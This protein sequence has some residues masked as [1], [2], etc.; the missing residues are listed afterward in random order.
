MTESCSTQRSQGDRPTIY[1][2]RITVDD[3]LDYLAGG[4]ALSEFAAD[5]PD[6][7]DEDVRDSGF[8]G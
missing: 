6:L 3:M 4:Q 7:R 2:A 1:G 5:F 8:S